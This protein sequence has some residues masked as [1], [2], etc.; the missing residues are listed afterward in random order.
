MIIQVPTEHASS[1]TRAWRTYTLTDGSQPLTRVL[2]AAWHMLVS[3]LFS[4]CQ[5][6][7]IMKVSHM[8]IRFQQLYEHIMT[9]YCVLVKQVAKSRILHFRLSILFTYPH[10]QV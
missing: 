3:D 6:V 1:I 10:V 7:V 5:K 9:F 4:L 8:L 2:A